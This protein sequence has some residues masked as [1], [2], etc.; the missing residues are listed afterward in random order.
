MAYN[1][2]HNKEYTTTKFTSTRNIQPPA[3]CIQVV[4][5][6]SYPVNN[7]S[8]RKKHLETTYILTYGKAGKFWE[9]WLHPPTRI[10]NTDTSLYSMGGVWHI[11]EGR[12]YVLRRPIVENT[13]IRLISKYNLECDLT[14][15][16][17]ELETYIYH[18]Q[19]THPLIKLLWNI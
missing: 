15:N 7:P 4:Q 3:E 2:W 11:P 18:L 19:V 17:L 10:N 16:K 8:E 14:I 6:K 1:Y 12:W 5:G 9:L 13:Q